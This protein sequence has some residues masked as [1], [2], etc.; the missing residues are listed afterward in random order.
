MHINVKLAA[1]TLVD[2]NLTGATKAVL[3]RPFPNG[4]PKRVLGGSERTV[5]R[6]LL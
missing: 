6:V 3:P 4:I 2:I 1:Y 5:P